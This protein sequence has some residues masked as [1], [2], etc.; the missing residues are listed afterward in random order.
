M[1]LRKTALH[2]LHQQLGGRMVEF[3]GWSM[4]VQYAGTLKEHQAVRQSVGI[5]DVSHMGE[6]EIT[7]PEALQAA[8]RLTCNDLTRIEDGQ[9]QYSAFL[10]PEGTFVDDIVVYRFS[11]RRIFICVNA[12]NRD[13]DFKWVSEH[14][15]GEAEASDV[16]DFYSQFAIQG[17]RSEDVLQ[18]LTAS[19]L[20]AIR[21]YRFQVGQ[22]DGVDAII[23]RTGYT[24]EAGFEIYLDPRHSEQVFR[25]LLKAGEGEDIQP[26][27]L[28]ARNTLR[29]EVCFPLYGNDIDSTTTP[30]E[31]GLGWIA[32]LESDDFIGRE[33]LRRQKEEGLERKLIAFEMVDRGIARDGYPVILEG[34]EVGRV[35]SGSYGPTVEKNIGLTYLPLEAAQE[36]R[37]FEIEIRGRRAAA[38]VVAKPFYKK[39]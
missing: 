7:G 16:G 15:S 19:D 35:R 17:P 18:R 22:V 32:K 34:Q 5:F 29:L 13:K 14:L 30:L 12:A 21:Y 24:G 9:A 10:T 27:G 28:A 11:T 39:D 31:A 3:A 23:S 1:N 33:A 6:I 36:G 37:S 4:P 8:Q 20:S 26:A 2:S 25:A 38:K